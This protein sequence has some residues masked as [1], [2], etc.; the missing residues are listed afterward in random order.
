MNA[1]VDFYAF[2]HFQTVHASFAAKPE[3]APVM[4]DAIVAT[5]LPFSERDTGHW[6]WKRTRF[7]T[8]CS[9]DDIPK[10]TPALQACGRPS[11]K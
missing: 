11:S 5:G 4:R 2:A 7:H 6:F 9:F 10:L 8:E 1:P 3:A